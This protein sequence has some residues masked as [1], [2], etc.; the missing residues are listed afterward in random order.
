[1]RDAPAW[2]TNGYQATLHQGDFDLSV[3]AAQLQ[4][5]MHQIQFQ[6]QSLPNF[7]LLRLSLPE[8]DDPIPANLIAE[9]YTR[10]SDFIASY[11][12]QS[13]YGFSPQVYWRAQVSGAIRGVEV[14]ISMQT[15]VLD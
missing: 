9:A 4:H 10:G 3:D 1:M 2:R 12:P 5:G 7:R 6:G 11:R 14:M 8:L 15:D 13:S